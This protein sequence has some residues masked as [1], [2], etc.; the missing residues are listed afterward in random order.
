MKRKEKCS[1]RGFDSRHLHQ[2]DFVWYL[3]SSEIDGQTQTPT[4]GEMTPLVR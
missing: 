4:F 1:G 2:E 3:N